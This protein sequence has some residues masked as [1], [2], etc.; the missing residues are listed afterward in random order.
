MVLWIV[1]LGLGYAE[2]ITV[3][4][5]NAVKGCQRIYLEHYTSILVEDTAALVELYGQDVILADREMVETEADKILEGADQQDVAFLV[6]GDPYGATTH[7]DL[8]IRARDLGITVKVVHNASIM[9]ACG[10]CGLQL[11]RFGET[12]SIPWFIGSWQP[13]S[14]YERI[15]SNRN[16]DLHTLCLLDIKVKEPN[17]EQL[18]RGRTVY[19]PARY[20]SVAQAIE[21]LLQIEDSKQEAAYSRDT[22]CIG[23]GRVGAAD[24]VIAAGPMGALMSYDMGLPLHSMVICAPTL[25]EQESTYLDSY[26]IAAPDAGIENYPTNGGQ[27]DNYSATVRRIADRMSSIPEDQLRVVEAMIAGLATGAAPAA[28]SSTQPQEEEE[29]VAAPA[30]KVKRVVKASAVS[31][32]ND[33]DEDGDADF[34]MS[35]AGED[36]LGLMFGDNSD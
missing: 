15:Q 20:M 22:M 1:G 8:T 19:E 24:Q 4:G 30:P 12:V 7:T 35:A 31:A 27:S 2:D 17:L 26:R 11:Y 18:A 32:D 14:F 25:H 28:A 6:V 23:L 9:N 3:R 16:A 33:D 34:D 29:E 13:D 10:C 36:D 5:L 21:Q